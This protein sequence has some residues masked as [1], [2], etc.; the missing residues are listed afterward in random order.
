MDF[1]FKCRGE[2]RVLH[3]LAYG[4]HNLYQSQPLAT[5]ENVG[6]KMNLYFTYESR[7]TL[8]SYSLFLVVN[9]MVHGIN[10]K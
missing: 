5:V 9:H 7:D 1:T 10:W 8:K 2:L 6:Y 4:S 3:F